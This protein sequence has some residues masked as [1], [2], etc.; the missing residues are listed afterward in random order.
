MRLDLLS[1]GEAMVELSASPDPALWHLGFAGDTLNTAWYLRRLLPAGRAVGYL[2]RIGTGG[3]S[4]RLRDFIADAGIVTDHIS[5][6]PVREAG[7][8]AIE[9]SQGERSFTYWRSDSAARGLADDPAA[10]AAAFA[11]ADMIYLSGITAAILPP[12][13]RDNL[14]AALDAARARGARVVFDTNI[15]P[16]L[17]EDGATLRTQITRFAGLADLVLPSLDE[18]TAHFGDGAPQDC[19]AR[20]LAAGAR[21]VVV[22]NGGGPVHYGG[23]D[24]AG[25]VDDLPR[26]RP[27]DTT[28]AGDSFNAG[29][30]AA[31]LGGAGIPDAIRAGH[32]IAAKVIAARG[33]L[34]PV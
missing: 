28:A 20:Y 6:D 1:V 22:K 3:F 17:W 15:R 8:Y 27:V 24:G 7:L 18:E 10:L 31:R 32:D 33:A 25:R 12:A 13:D 5:A 23:V 2:T 4:R 29:Y 34:V 11:Q 21:Q 9:L 30:L 14:A 19:I 16:R 26:V